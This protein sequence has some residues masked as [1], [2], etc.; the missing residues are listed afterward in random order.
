[1]ELFNFL[2]TVYIVLLFSRLFL[3]VGGELLFNPLLRTI[4]KLTE[5]LLQPLRRVV[6]PR[7]T[8][9]DPSPLVAAT[10]LLL[11][12]GF[13]LGL[14]EGLGAKGALLRSG[15]VLVDF[16]YRAYGVLLLG[17]VF[18]SL[19][20]AFSH[21][22]FTQIMLNMTDPTLHP[23]RRFTGYRERGLDWAPLI[24][25]ALLIAV[26]TAVVL[27]V[28]HI[29]GASEHP[30]NI[31]GATVESTYILVDTL[32][33]FLMVVMIA[34]VVVSW[35]NLDPYNPLV[36]AVIFFSDPILTPIRRLIPAWTVGLDF[37]P[38]FGIILLMVVRY[39]VHRII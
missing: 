16:V 27:S 4:V 21:S 32:I 15:L 24:G 30:A 8:G 13:L 3:P 17:V 2:I 23:L 26:R 39:M 37:S 36:Q 28:L 14:S 33:T 29:L 12:R 31:R 1:M 9:F 20:S 10:L 11:I 35:I 22:R 25:M 7:R 34:R 19:G 18:V 6:P 38:M 5:P